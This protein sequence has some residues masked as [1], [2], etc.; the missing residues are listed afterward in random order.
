VES[1]PG[2]TYFGWPAYIDNVRISDEVETT[3][4]ELKN[5]ACKV[6]GEW[7][8]GSFLVQQVTVQGTGEDLLLPDV[9]DN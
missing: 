1:W 8:D 6:V 7:A 2:K 9:I 4:K 5:T 3:L